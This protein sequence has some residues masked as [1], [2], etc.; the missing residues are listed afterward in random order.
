MSDPLAQM[1]DQVG[2][3]LAA[4]G[5]SMETLS[6]QAL[7]EV[8][9][10]APDGLAL[11]AA[12]FSPEHALWF[13]E[14]LRAYLT[15]AEE[16]PAGEM[17]DTSKFAPAMAAAFGA[18]P[19]SEAERK[20]LMDLL[21]NPFEPPDEAPEP[22]PSAEPAA[23]PES[24]EEMLSQ[25]QKQAEELRKELDAKLAEL[26]TPPEAAPPEGAAPAAEAPQ[27]SENAVSK[28]EKAVQ[29]LQSALDEHLGNL[30]KDPYPG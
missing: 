13:F 29:E 22:P 21:L 1:L 7:G 2:Q 20:E 28:L 11:L 25:L 27:P 5:V 12:R 16:A 18:L 3:E 9:M 6:R 4:Q 10:E 26:K 23:P 24:P 19:I 17:P 30:P 14:F 8:G 15:S